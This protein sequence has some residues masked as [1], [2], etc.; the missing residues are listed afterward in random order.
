MDK[1]ELLDWV[2]MEIGC[3]C[4]TLRETERN[5][6]LKFLDPT[7]RIER[8]IIALRELYKIL[9][10]EPEEEPILDDVELRY[11][12]SVLRPF[13]DRAKYVTKYECGEPIGKK[14]EF[15]DFQMEPEEYFVLP[16]FE[17]GTMYKNMEP[18]KKYTLEE[19]GIKYDK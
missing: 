5:Y 13:K 12:K 18:R 15:I 17:R 2:I 14:L 19:L 4:R 11:L 6:N 10:K 8:N 1:K 3:Q 9:A 7:K 16:C